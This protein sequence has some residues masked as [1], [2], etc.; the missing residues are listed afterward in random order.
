MRYI[1]SLI[2]KG[3]HGKTKIKWSSDSNCG[4]FYHHLMYH[5]LSKITIIKSMLLLILL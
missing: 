3:G 1:Y 5:N 2:M 4:A